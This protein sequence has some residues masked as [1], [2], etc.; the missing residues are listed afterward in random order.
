MPATLIIIEVI[1]FLVLA[2]GVDNI[3]IMV[4][5]FLM[6]EQEE[7]GEEVDYV[8]E[9]D[10][11][12]DCL[13]DDSGAVDGEEIEDIDVKRSR[14]ASGCVGGVGKTKRG[15][16][17]GKQKNGVEK[18]RTTVEARIAKTMGRVGPSMFLSS[19]AESVAFFCGMWKSIS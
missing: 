15:H 12:E 10:E 3:F 8:E 2:V 18:E 4:Q 19:L 5:D 16:R 6:H 1:P 14:S 17:R 9:D 13:A 11:E 7:L